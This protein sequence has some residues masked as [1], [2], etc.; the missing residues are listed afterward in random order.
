MK[1]L[2]KQREEKQWWVLL[3]GKDINVRGNAER[4]SEVSL[5]GGS[6]VKKALSAQPYAALAWSGASLLLPV[7]LS[8]EP[9]SRLSADQAASS[10]PPVPRNTRL[11]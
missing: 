5:L 2:S 3:L 6:V 7:G 4:A 9:C 8:F 11:C 10:S 1:K